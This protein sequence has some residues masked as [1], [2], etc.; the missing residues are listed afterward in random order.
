MSTNTQIQ[1]PQK[2]SLTTLKLLTRAKP[3]LEH[4][5]SH[6][7]SPSGIDPLVAIHGLDNT[8]EFTLRIIADHIDFEKITGKSFPD[9]ELSQMA[10]ELNRLFRDF[11]ST[12]LPLRTDRSLQ[13]WRR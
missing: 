10:G 11:A 3:L 1:L 6:A 13:R 8:I 9:S 12:G 4:A 7:S 2:P 5:L